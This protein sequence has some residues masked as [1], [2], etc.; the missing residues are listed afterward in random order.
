MIT[1]AYVRTMAEYNAE[2][3]ETAKKLAALE[4]KPAAK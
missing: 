1:P 3:A 4:K 2:M